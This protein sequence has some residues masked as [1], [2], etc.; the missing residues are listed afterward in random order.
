[1]TQ[2]WRYEYGLPLHLDATRQHLWGTHMWLPV[3]TLL[4]VLVCARA[5]MPADQFQVYCARLA[6][7][8]KHHDALSEM[9]PVLHMPY[10][11]PARFEV[12]GLGKGQHTIDWHIQKPGTRPILID[13][14]RRIFDLVK[15]MDQPLAGAAPPPDHDASMLFRSVEEKFLAVDRLSMLQGAWI[16]TE[17]KQEERALQAAFA[18]LDPSKVQF[19]ILGSFERDVCVLSHVPEDAEEILETLALARSSRLTFRGG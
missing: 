6:S 11:V 8:G 12:Q 5:R 14:K 3:R 17:I 18:A 15:Q 4:Q 1:M 13:V 7:E 2:R 10:G 19:A 9:A 16:H